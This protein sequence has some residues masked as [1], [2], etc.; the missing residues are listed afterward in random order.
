MGEGILPIIPDKK[1]EEGLFVCLS[2]SE[3]RESRAFLRFFFLRRILIP[4]KFLYGN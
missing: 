1:G 3:R 2:T 4:P